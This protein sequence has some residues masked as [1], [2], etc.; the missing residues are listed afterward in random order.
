MPDTSNGSADAVACHL[1]YPD[2]AAHDAEAIAVAPDGTVR[3]IRKESSPP[4][5]LYQVSHLD[6]DGSVQTLQEE[7]E[8]T[9]DG[10]V[11]GATMNSD[12]SALILRSH[13][14][15]WIWTGCS[16]NVDDEPELTNLP[17]EPFGEA[18]AVAADGSLVTTQEQAEFLVHVWPCDTAQEMECTGCG[19]TTWPR[20]VAWVGLLP[21]VLVATRFRARVVRS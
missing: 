20:S 10:A 7:A 21:L 6:C 1:A 4:T 15:A 11:T 14:S 5:H 2:G 3:I 19:C 8:L 9:L 17:G 16:P 18:V 12:G 13:D